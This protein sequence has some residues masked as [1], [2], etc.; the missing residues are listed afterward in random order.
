MLKPFTFSD[1]SEEISDDRVPP[2]DKKGAKA[3]NAKQQEWMDAGVLYLPN[4]MPEALISQYSEARSKIERPGG[5]KSATPY[6]FV[7]EIKEIGLYP[8][9]MAQMKNLVGDDM[10]MHLNLT[11]WVSTQR[12]WHQDDLL[13]PP[14]ITA[15][16]AA[17]WIA[18]DDIHLD[19]GPFQYVPG[20]HKWPLVRRDKLFK[21]MPDEWKTRDDW[22]ILT[23]DAVSKCFEDEATKRGAKVETYLPK[24]GDV[25]IWHG[26]LM[27][28]GSLPNVP[29]M[30]RKSLICHYSALS[31]RIDMPVRAQHEGGGWYFVLNQ[32][33]ETGL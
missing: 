22:P 6:M 21:Y 25:L 33:T 29:G 5:W 31:K 7:P 11:G 16:Y 12:N 30:L 26:R 3:E 2:L 32:G 13:N 17:V 8:P 23:Q 15:H 28:R 10:G 1:V 18:L 4:F 9:L 27:H 24:K 20:S 14:F 19:S